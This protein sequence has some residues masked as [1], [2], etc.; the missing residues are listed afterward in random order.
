MAKYTP[1]PREYELMVLLSP[2]LGDEAL[3]AEMQGISDRIAQTGATVLSSKATTPW[4]RR[5][6]AYPI[7]NHQDAFYVLYSI[8]SQPGG[9]DPFERDLK[10]NGN[11]L[12]YLLIRQEKTSSEPEES[13]TEEESGAAEEPEAQTAQTE[14][15]AETQAESDTTATEESAAEEPAATSEDAAEEEPATASS[16]GSEDEQV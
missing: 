9:L 4:G 1:E 7:D 6:L 12:R 15:A 8:S 13:E 14:E 5:R 2:E 3:E 11:V 10:L 16:E